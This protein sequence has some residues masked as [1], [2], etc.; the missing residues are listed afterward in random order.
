MS[1]SD[2]LKGVVARLSDLVAAR[3]HAG[4][5]FAPGG[6]VRTH[7]FGGHRSSFRG[8]GM[9]FDEVRVYH[10]GD[11]VR[12]IDWRVTARTGKPH[13][14][15][16]QEE[17]ERPVLILTD[18]RARMRFGTRG[19]FKSV[20]AAE[21]AAVLSWVGIAGGD[22]VGGV[23]LAPSAVGA[24]KPERSRRR[25]LNFVRAIADATAER[26]GPVGGPAGEPSLAEA[27]ARMR[28]LARPGTLVFLV[29]DFA[30]FDEHAVRELERLAMDSHVTGLFVYDR[31][32]AAMPDPGRYPVTDGVRIAR[33]EADD[34]AARAA[35][36]RRFAAHHDHVERA[37]RER[38]MTF[39]DLATGTDPADVLHPERLRPPRFTG[40]RPA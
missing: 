13:T 28:A 15:L 38:G 6:K 37:F 11:D 18:A 34:E 8:R 27:L 10:P 22:R 1:G 33:L 40:R 29:S 21:A 35:H 30:D 36:A 24:Y 4:G 5:G 23:V 39:L 20:L 17:R 12:T 19:S 16:F 2:P 31:L 7:Q 26:A 25:I 9:E 3:P 32:E 14:K